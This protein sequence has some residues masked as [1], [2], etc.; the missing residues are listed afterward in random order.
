MADQRIRLLLLALL[1]TLPAFSQR[2]A[3]RNWQGSGLTA[4]TWWPRATLCSI[5]LRTDRTRRVP[6]LVPRLEE[7]QAIGCEALVLDVLTP[8]GGSG[9][10]VAL[11]FGT[12]EDTDTLIEQMGR[13]RMRLILSLPVPPQGELSRPTLGQMRFWLSRGVAGFLLRNAGDAPDTAAF[14]HQA[15]QVA[16]S[17]LGTRLLLGDG[18][19]LQAAA[20]AAP[21]RTPAPAAGPDIQLA[22]RHLAPAGDRA[23][24]AALRAALSSVSATPPLPLL[25]LDG[26]A[27]SDRPIVPIDVQFETDSH[28]A[29]AAILLGQGAAAMLPLSLLNS[30][31]A[32]SSPG[33][34]ALTPEELTLWIPAEGDPLG[35]SAEKELSGWLRAL[36]DLRHS[37][38]ALRTGAPT[39][40]DLDL[41]EF[42]VWV[43]RPKG[44]GVPLL[45]VCNLSSSAAAV[46]ITAELQAAGLHFSTLSPILRSGANPSSQPPTLDHLD[47][48]SLG[49]L[50]AELR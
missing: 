8:P 19:S 2:L 36:V 13:R 40:L 18:L 22:L 30:R 23:S 1:S 50:I 42:L 43:V 20:D 32:Q 37:S 25:T 15:H 5:D 49:V 45:F 29:R 33:N 24:I 46:S 16:A 35:P 31:Q 17:A 14:V 47:L 41:N 38:A 39:Y 27:S 21:R 9:S 11:T 48:P 10:P 28:R 44:T 12:L 3:Q 26:P 6:G 7:L 4:Q 34:P